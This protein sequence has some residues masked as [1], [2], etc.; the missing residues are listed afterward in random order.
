[1][2]KLPTVTGKQLIGILLKDG[3]TK[4]GH[5][6]HGVALVKGR[7]RTVVQNISRPLKSG[8]LMAI[9][10]PRQTRLGKAGLQR[11]IDKH[12]L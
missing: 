12:G 4:K 8:T 10:G 5:R 1:M 11:L 6:R 3:W 2:G 7:L 9:L